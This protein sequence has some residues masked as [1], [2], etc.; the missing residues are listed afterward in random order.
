MSYPRIEKPGPKSY[1]GYA[2][3]EES[4]LPGGTSPLIISNDDDD[5]LVSVNKLVVRADPDPAP[6][7][8]TVTPAAPQ[9]QA[10]GTDTG[11]GT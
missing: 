4:L 6:T 9:Q 5:D 11:A 1:G 8:A 10:Q 3:A 7:A 2:W